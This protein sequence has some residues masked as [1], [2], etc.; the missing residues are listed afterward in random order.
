MYE[1]LSGMSGTALTEAVEFAKIYKLDVVP[2]PTHRPMVRDD[3]NDQVFRS[4]E[5]KYRAVVR[6]IIRCHVVG[7]PALVGTASIE[8]SERLSSYLK[9]GA[10]KNLAL[11]SVLMITIRDTKKV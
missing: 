1:K 2:I 9:P 4:E 6:E 3:L 11:S 8:N 5:A 10:L 7:Q